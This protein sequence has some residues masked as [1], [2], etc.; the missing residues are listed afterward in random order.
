MAKPRKHNLKTSRDVNS[1]YASNRRQFERLNKALAEEEDPDKRNEIEAALAQTMRQQVVIWESK[2]A[3]A[4]SG[5]LSQSQ[6][7][8]ELAKAAKN[9]LSETK[10]I[11]KLTK[12]LNSVA[13]TLGILTR[14]LA[15]LSA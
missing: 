15:A 5:A 6:A 9:A 13:A 7:E 1:L 12:A 11:A 4:R 14:L 8:K 2:I 3:F 10:A